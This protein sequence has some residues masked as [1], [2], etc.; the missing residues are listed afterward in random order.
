MNERLLRAPTTATS[1]KLTYVHAAVRAWWLAEYSG[2]Y[3][4]NYEGS[5]PQNQLTEESNQRSRQFTDALKDGAFDCMISVSADMKG[6]WYDPAREGLRSWL[7]RKAPFL[8][9]TP[10]A[11]FSGFFQDILMDQLQTFAE[12]FVLNLPN[13]LRKLRTEE[14]EQRQS[15]ATHDQDVDMERFLVIISYVFDGR[16]KAAADGFW[17][18]PDGGLM[19]FLHWVS[20]RASTP[21][22][23]AFCEMLQ[24]ISQDEDCATSV[25]EFLV[26]EG[27]QKTRRLALTWNH[28]IKELT[29]FSKSIRDRPAVPQTFGSGKSVT[30]HAELEPE[31]YLMLEEYLRVVA[32][33]VATS[34]AARE[35]FIT[36]PTFQLHEILLH[37]VSSAITP[38][39]RA[40]AFTALR[41]LLS[42]K[43]KTVGEY[44]WTALD[45]WISG[46]YSPGSTM[47]KVTPISFSST[48][49]ERIL[50]GLSNGFE[51]PNAF[52]QL[53]TAL[54]SPYEGET[55]LKDGL[56]FPETLGVANR[57]PGIEPY[58]DFVLG[59]ILG[60]Q[61][62]EIYDVK[63][64]RMLQLSCL[65]F[66]AMSLDTFNEDLVI[67][68]NKTNINVEFAMETTDLKTYVL[69]HPFSRVMEWMF[70]ERVMTALFSAIH[71]DAEAV[72]IAGQDSPL[73]RCV[74][75]GIHVVSRILDLQATYLDIVRP[76]VKTQASSQ[77]VPVSSAAYTSFE[78]G[79][80]SHLP[81]IA[82]LGLYC[83]AGQPELVMASL[84]LL[85]KLS[86]STKLASMTVTGMGRL[87]NR[88]K[89]IAALE[90]NNDS[91]AI[92]RS[93]LHEMKARIDPNYG[94]EHSS[95]V[96]QVRILDFLAACLKASPGQPTIAHLL[97]GFKC[98]NSVI[99]ID[100]N[101][102]FSQGVSLFHCILEIVM[103]APVTLD[104]DSNVSNYLMTLKNK[105][106][107]VLSQLWQSPLSSG[108]VMEEMRN[109]RSLFF[110]FGKLTR[111]NDPML[112]DGRPV[113]DPE[114][115]E[116]SS[117]SVLSQ[118]LSHRATLLQY[119]SAE[120]R[121]VARSRLPSLRSKI[122]ATLLGS[123]EEDGQIN[124]HLDVFDLFDFI[125]LEFPQQED[126]I[127]P[128]WIEDVDFSLCLESHH[129]ATQTYNLEKVMEL[130]VLRKK[131]LTK[132]RLL[133]ESEDVAT[134]DLQIQLIS[135]H[136]AT[137]NELK[138][139]RASRLSLL[140]SWVQLMLV[141][142]EVNEISGEHKTPFMLQILQIILPIL[143]NRLE[144]VEDSMELAR[145]AKSLLFSLDFDSK[146]FKQGEIGDAVSDRLF[147]LFQV[148]LRAIGLLGAYPNLKELFYTIIYRY[149]TGMSD[150]TGITKI[151][152]R[153]STQT[154]KAAGERFVDLICD[155]AHS[156]EPMCRISAL[157]LLGALVKM[158]DKE[159]SKYV[160][161]SLGRMNFISILVESI[162]NFGEDLRNT[163]HEGICSRSDRS[164]NSLTTLDV[165]TQISYCHAR[166]SLLLQISQTR[167]G[168][169][170][171]MNAGIIHSI[172]VSGLFATDPDLGVGESEE[173]RFW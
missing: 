89:A 13:V 170:A 86:T 57:M 64:S 163:P 99:D 138:I 84:E 116:S 128:P 62:T 54:I 35:F 45:G 82:D 63:L 4:E 145:L 90:V 167:V 164:I 120:L 42:Q 8:Q 112:F 88:N 94:A 132:G 18:N 140:Q 48:S 172:Q 29:F 3:G 133:D 168:A 166:L 81:V 121:Q 21:L 78:D 159:G 27:P 58:I 60:S 148:S 169:A 126:P 127:L 74:L 5:L 123:T 85:E 80:L 135:N 93:L 129:G 44:I 47:A 149:L 71:Q 158:A 36:H 50:K 38:R 1:W 25:H 110:M 2:W 22:V 154:I 53:L 83:G 124:E 30:E 17:D 34:P 101:S 72:G 70:N 19:G 7:Q 32:R 26:D 165:N 156:G 139:Y 143:E 131:E 37:L 92:A 14:D 106:I 9:I 105:A 96:I 39:I 55:G 10:H 118:F 111:L 69:M 24:A 76:I 117:A 46:G 67:F 103:L 114:L 79:I 171:V 119:V 109:V 144:N 11:T 153:H 20:T 161:E 49:T 162:Q 28:I 16:P 23:S 157:L 125:E 151:Q 87:A 107:Q 122:F 97:L 104:E 31:T 141:M 146:S 51:E 137:D 108:L 12:N 113:Q 155:D 130:L 65:D 91:D 152:R 115:F 73:M 33:V 134:V 6:E 41:S 77:R 95:Y 160:V 173:T 142:I 15:S 68:A 40:A 100:P 43:T 59:Q 61:Y 136:Y 52:V 56:P 75:Q 66:I 147:H 150:V 98:A 102:F